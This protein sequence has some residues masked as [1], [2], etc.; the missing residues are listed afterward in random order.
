ME[1]QHR[2]ISGYR[3]LSQAEIDTMN[4][5]KELEKQVL[6]LVNHMGYADHRWT[7]IGKTHIQQ[8]FMALV[9]A[10]ARPAE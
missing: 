8:G 3:E 2:M 4:E 1:N 7:A 5:L 6:E 9:R 10:I